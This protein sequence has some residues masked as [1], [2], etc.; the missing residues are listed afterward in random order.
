MIPSYFTIKFLHLDAIGLGSALRV[1]EATYSYSYSRRLSSLNF[2]THFHC[3][4]K[5]FLLNGF[6]SELPILRYQNT[7]L[8]TV[9]K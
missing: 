5:S 1:W 4:Q 7:R 9:H 2:L 6:L 8:H 3:S